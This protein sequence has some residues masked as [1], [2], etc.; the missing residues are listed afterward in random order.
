MADGRGRSLAAAMEP[1]Y[2]QRSSPIRYQSWPPEYA[3]SRIGTAWLCTT[4]STT[5]LSSAT[6]GRARTLSEVEVTQPTGNCQ[7]AAPSEASTST[8]WADGQK[9]HPAT[10]HPTVI[11]NAIPGGAVAQ[12]L[13]VDGH[14]SPKQQLVDRRVVRTHARLCAHVQNVRSDDAASRV[15]PGGLSG[16]VSPVSRT[17]PL[18]THR[19]VPMRYHTAPAATLSS[20]I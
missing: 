19:S 7:T 1:L 3:E 12:H 2:A 5:G 16:G 11:A 13:L 10:V 20:K 6:P 18:C 9:T 17:Q 15:A 8:C 4:V 14:S